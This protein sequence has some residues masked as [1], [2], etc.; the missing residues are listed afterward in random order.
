MSVPIGDDLD[1]SFISYLVN[2]LQGTD[3]GIDFI[4]GSRDYSDN[5]RYPAVGGRL[6][7]GSKYLKLGGFDH[8]GPIQSR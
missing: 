8:G 7:L 6:S 3:S 1:L 2:G 4:F 5:N